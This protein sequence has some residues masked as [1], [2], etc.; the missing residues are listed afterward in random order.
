MVLLACRYAW[1]TD[2]FLGQMAYRA[3]SRWIALGIPILP[4]IAHGIAMASAQICI[5]DIVVM[6][7]GVYIAHGQ[8]VAGGFTKI[9]TG[10]V[11]FPWV[12]IGLRKNPMG[13]VIGEG[14]HIGSGARV[15]GPI[16]IGPGAEIGAN[17]VV[18]DDV[19]PGV[20][21]VGI[22]ARPTRS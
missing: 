8:I 17:A 1:A 9:H 21:V 2:A 7:P 16:T 20:T 14:V 19:A 5:D 4:R 12:T 22:P 13:P 15:I 10:V 11:I 3:K 18:L 6:Q